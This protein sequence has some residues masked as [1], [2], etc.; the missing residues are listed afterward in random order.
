M[1]DKVNPHTPY[2]K[3][4]DLGALSEQGAE[5]VL[6]PMKGTAPRG[7]TLADRAITLHVAN[8]RALL[9][10]LDADEIAQFGT[11]LAKL[12]PSLEPKAKPRR[13]AP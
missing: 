2:F 5:I 3:S 13:P 6:R 12:L 11:L 10:A 9:E 7:R 8:E 4:Y 1:S